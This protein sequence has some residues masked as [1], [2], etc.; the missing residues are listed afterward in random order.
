MTAQYFRIFRWH[1]LRYLR[2]HPLLALLNILSVAL[3]VSVYLATQIANHSANRAFAATVDLV[4][5]KAELEITAPAGHLPD[6]SFPAVA[7]TNG[8]SA[9]T[10][11]VRG[12]VTLPD[13]PGEYLE[14]I[15]IDVFTNEQFRTFDPSGFEAA[16]LDIQQW[17]GP[18]G[19][20]ALSEE[21]VA[22]HHL[23]A[24][25]KIRARVNVID[26][27]LRVGFILRSKG[28]PILDA[29]F[30][31]MDLGW[32]QELF[33]RRGELSAIQLRLNNPRDR[34]K[35][36][37]EL[38]KVLPADASVTAPVQRTEEVDKM[39]GGFEL[40]LSAMSLVSL[41]VGMFLIYNT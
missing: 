7:A 34:P 38:R 11:I 2:R 13:F 28:A 32:A 39:L 36:V 9:A 6:T 5:G 37:A 14:V 19:S 31:A 29:H 18:P 1:V 16:D 27:D 41:V 20:I 23:K 12:L 25:D 3:G 24:G 33:A 26:H 17:L 15:G 30:A 40:N 8:I 35:V 21:F 10:P 22:R 4:A